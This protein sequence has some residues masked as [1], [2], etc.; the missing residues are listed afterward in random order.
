MQVTPL[1]NEDDELEHFMAML[2]EVDDDPVV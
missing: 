1:Y 2:H